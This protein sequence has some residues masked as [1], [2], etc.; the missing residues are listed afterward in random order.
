MAGISTITQAKN[1]ALS[2]I[3]I[4]HHNPSAALLARERIYEMH[5][6]AKDRLGA[7]KNNKSARESIRWTYDATWDIVD[8]VDL[9]LSRSD[10]NEDLA[11]RI[12]T[13]AYAAITSLDSMAEEDRQKSELAILSMR[14]LMGVSYEPE[15]VEAADT[16]TMED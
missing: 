7:Y 11:S 4:A 1:R 5:K 9:L 8:A 15:P 14:K 3:G 16:D 6:A 12:F 2:A 13:L 10:W